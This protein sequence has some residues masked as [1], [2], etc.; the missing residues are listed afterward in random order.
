[1]PPFLELYTDPDD[2]AD[3]TNFVEI[4]FEGVVPG[5]AVIA[6]IILEGINVIIDPLRRFLPG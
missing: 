1:M 6:R 3:D 2:A 4:C 5:L